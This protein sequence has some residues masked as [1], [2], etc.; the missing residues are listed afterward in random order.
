MTIYDVENAILTGKII[1]RQKDRETGEAKFL[2]R[3]KTVA[4]AD[5][6]TAATKFGFSGKLIIITV[7]VD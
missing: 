3:G 6:L 5:I 4:G 2:V 7:Y 1:K